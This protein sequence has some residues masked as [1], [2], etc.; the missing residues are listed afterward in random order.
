MKKHLKI[1]IKN[2]IAYIHP[3]S[4]TIDGIWVFSEPTFEAVVAETET[5]GNAL[6]RALKLS[7]QEVPRPIQNAVLGDA[8]L[9]TIGVASWSALYKSSFAI[10]VE[11][12]GDVVR[13]TPLEYGGS[14][15]AQKG[16]HP[17]E[18]QARSTTDD[19]LAIAK[20]IHS[21]SFESFRDS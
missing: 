6:L 1:F 15:G 8:F 4:R 14:Q 21:M 3:E 11:Q 12:D 10:D 5:F 19:A 18:E 9:R 17:V 20:V 13:L 16:L 2:E 7:N